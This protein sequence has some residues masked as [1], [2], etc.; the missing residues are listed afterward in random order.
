MRSLAVRI[1]REETR[2][3]VFT[4]CLPLLKTKGADGAVEREE[5][6]ELASGTND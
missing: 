5:T 1:E 3:R 6:A 2:I 4:A